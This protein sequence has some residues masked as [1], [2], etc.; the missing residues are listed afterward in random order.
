M[1]AYLFSRG[2]VKQGH[3]HEFVR[4]VKKISEH[5]RKRAY[6]VPEVLY[7]LSG[8][9]NTVLLRFAFADLGKLD[10]AVDHA[11]H[12]AALTLPVTPNGERRFGSII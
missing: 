12:K 3:L 7:G 6:C 1:A 4:A 9:M 8:A 2:V 5:R 10:I 11:S